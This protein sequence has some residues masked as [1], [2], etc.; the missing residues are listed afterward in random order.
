M[1]QDAKGEGMTINTPNVAKSPLA[2]PATNGPS[3]AMTPAPTNT[4]ALDPRPMQQ[5]PMIA[6]FNTGVTAFEALV[7]RF[8]QAV[9]RF[10]AANDKLSNS[11]GK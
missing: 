8:E 1:E 3:T 2:K 7:S 10:A 5:G 4:I 11:V 9:T 6:S